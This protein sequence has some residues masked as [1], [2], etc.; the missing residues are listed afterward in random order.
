MVSGASY[1][2]GYSHGAPEDRNSQGDLQGHHRTITD[3]T[4]NIHNINFGN[5]LNLNPNPINY[6]RQD[7]VNASV[8]AES[9]FSPPSGGVDIT[10]SLYGGDCHR[11]STMSSYLPLRHSGTHGVP[12]TPRGPVG[13]EDNVMHGM[14]GVMD[15]GGGYMEHFLNIPEICPT[16]G[17]RNPR[18]YMGAYNAD[19][20]RMEALQQQHR[21]HHDLRMG[22]QGSRPTFYPNMN[23]GMRFGD[24]MEAQV[25]T[26]CMPQQ[27]RTDTLSPCTKAVGVA[28]DTEPPSFY[29]WMSIVGPNSNQRRRGRQTYTRFQTLELEKE[30]KF[31]RYLTRRRRIEL[32]HMLCLTERQIKIW[33]QNRRMKEKKELQA[34]KEL[35]EQSRGHEKSLQH[36]QSASSTVSAK[37]EDKMAPSLTSSS[38]QHAVGSPNSSGSEHS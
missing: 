20:C 31:N 32:S 3:G 10:A 33:F 30:F 17:Y 22:L 27:N 18:Y 6:G 25:G 38:S 26:N 21:N 28:A 37:S 19:A 11:G 15:G 24:G 12:T 29:P 36:Q 9:G 5:N 14:G 7:Y 2:P 35:N 8:L 16:G 13:G 23:M 4:T 34:I 1:R